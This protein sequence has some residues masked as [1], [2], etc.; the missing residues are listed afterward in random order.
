MATNPWV[1]GT[2]FYGPDG[3]GSTIDSDNLTDTQ[4]EGMAVEFPDTDPTT[5]RVRSGD[6]VKGVLVR[7]TGSDLASPAGKTV[8]WA[9][10][11]RG[12][13]VGALASGAGGEAAGILD[14]RLGATLRQNDIVFIARNGPHRHL[15]HTTADAASAGAK[16]YVSANAGTLADIADASVTDATSQNLVGIAVDAVATPAND[17]SLRELYLTMFV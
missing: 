14:D 15:T 5:G 7:W 4:L 16:M 6:T 1:R 12:R 11:Y 8:S 17:A 10:G 9:T 13:R 2:T 3:F